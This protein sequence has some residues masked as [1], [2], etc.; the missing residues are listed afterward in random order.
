MKPG[1]QATKE[2]ELNGSPAR[3]NLPEA[4]NWG[5]LVPPAQWAV[6][7]KAI[8][9]A[10]AVDVPFMLGGA[11]GLARYTG[12]WRNT[13]DI[14]FFVRESD[15]D[16]LVG[17]LHRAG[18]VDYHSQLAY[19]RSW[20]YRA[21][22]EDVIVDVIWT[23]P[24]HHMVVDDEWFEHSQA[25]TLCDEELRVV[26]AEELL[27]IKIFVLQ[28]DRCDWPDLINLLSAVGA[29]L[30]WDRLQRRLANDLPLLHAVLLLFSWV[31]PAG[32]AA[33]PSKVRR[34]FRLPKNG[35]TNLAELEQKRVALLDS[36]P[37]YASFQSQN[38]PMQL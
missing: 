30:D 38:E 11:F 14:D 13:K 31:C 20:I 22:Q 3:G 4:F 7:K 24:N 12:R 34:Q 35:V 32:A 8:Q 18:F 37:W 1:G 2:K 27:W 10:R 23:T 9:A 25:V 17:A 33:L 16:R 28:R 21:T 29:D 36:R 26:P 15:R 19:D 5:A 6:Y